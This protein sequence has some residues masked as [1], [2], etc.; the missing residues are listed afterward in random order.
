M[1]VFSLA[2][3]EHRAALLLLAIVIDWLFGEPEWIWRY[4]PHPVVLCGKAISFTEQCGNQRRHRGR[5]R[6]WFGNIAMLSLVGLSAITGVA[7]HAGGPVII[8]IMLAIMLAGRSLDQ[9]ILAVAK[10]LGMGLDTARRSISMVVG[11]HTDTL[12]PA[13][14]SRAAIETGAEN[15]SDGVIAPAFWFLIGGLPALFIYKMTNT[16][17][18]MIG[19]RNS[20]FYAFGWAAARFDDLLN[21]IPARLTSLLIALASIGA[22]GGMVLALKTIWRDAGSHASPNAGWPESA[23]AGGLDLWLGGPRYYGRIVTQALK[24]N[25]NGGA[26]SKKDVYRAIRIMRLAYGVFA[27]LLLGMA[28]E[29]L[30]R[31]MSAASQIVARFISQNSIL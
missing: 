23:M 22:K 14:I 27:L 1:P 24:M 9:H 12:E 21:Y 10:G 3:V 20:R 11:R 16:A 17:D 30:P 26:A 25:P 19:Y 15:L 5:H 18:S 4:L 6:R 31:Y 13:E 7:A 8:V 28:A 2:E 29:T